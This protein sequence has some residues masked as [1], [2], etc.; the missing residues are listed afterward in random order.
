MISLNVFLI[1][2][3]LV[4]AGTLQ[5][6]YRKVSHIGRV[7]L[8]NSLTPSDDAA[9]KGAEN[10]LIVGVDSGEGLDP[11]DPVLIG[12][13]G[14]IRSDTIMILRLDP[15]SDKAQL[16][17]LPRDLWVPIAGR[18]GHD[19]INSAIQGGPRRLV[20]TI[21]NDF[22]IPINHYIEMNFL[23]FRKVVEAID[24]V[25]IYFSTP[26]R[27]RMTGLDVQDP[28]CITLDPVQALAFARSR[29]YEYYDKGRWHTDPTGDLGRISRQQEFIRRVIRRAIDKGA[30]NPAVL[31]DL[32]DA[33]TSALHL[34][35]TVTPAD[36]IEIGKRFRDFNPDNLETYSLPVV[37][38]NKGGAS[39]VLM[40]TNEAEPI[41]NVFRGVDANALDSILVLV[42]NGTTT[43]DMGATVADQLRNVGFSVPEGFTSNA[44]RFD[45]AQTTIRYLPGGEEHAQV[46]ASYLVA[47]PVFE[48]VEFL[49]N[50]DVD[51]VVGAD[52]QGLRTAPAP[53]VPLPTSTT[54]P[55]GRGR[56]STTTTTTTTLPSPGE[57]TTTTS[58]TVPGVVPQTPQDVHC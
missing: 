54:Q 29:D 40:Q 42:Q 37:G 15:A 35:P 2:V 5:Y 14:G 56:T 38:A 7:E 52:W 26:V 24:G 32:I 36:L 20:E 47:P 4:T 28:G 30:R 33:G 12:R 46:V 9:L 23:A 34:D 39:V 13:P 1:V 8:G 18:S 53:T 58:T 16:L 6:L 3:C 50:T 27:D 31:N 25:P 10:I 44:E 17:S 48:K 41:L 43:A 19:R 55:S 21:K 22:G 11:N 45:F 51:V 49:L 57:S